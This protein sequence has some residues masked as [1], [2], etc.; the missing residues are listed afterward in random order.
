MTQLLSLFASLI[1]L[2]TFYLY[3]KLSLCFNWAPRHDEGVE[4]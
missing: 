1:V 3:L 4:V 2:L